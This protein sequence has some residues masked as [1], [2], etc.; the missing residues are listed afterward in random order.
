MLLV[1]EAENTPIGS[2]T[3]SSAPGRHLLSAVGSS[4]HPAGVDQRSPAE[5]AAG[6]EDAQWLRGLQ[7]HLPRVLARCTLKASVDPLDFSLRD[8]G[9]SA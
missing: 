5:V 4:K 2:V 9:L 3:V 7:G 6:H 1:W 8:L